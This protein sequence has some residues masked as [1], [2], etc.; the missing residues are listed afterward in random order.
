MQA[1]DKAFDPMASAGG[2]VNETTSPN[3]I[4][5]TSRLVLNLAISLCKRLLGAY[6][7]VKISQPEINYKNP[8]ILSSAQLNAHKVC[9][10][11]LTT[12][13]LALTFFKY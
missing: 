12:D 6:N 9:N 5:G 3:D 13:C 8:E 1:L 4:M 2:R 11:N 7:Q 10:N